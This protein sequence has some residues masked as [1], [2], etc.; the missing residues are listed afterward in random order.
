M[1]ERRLSLCESAILFSA[2]LTPLDYYRAV[3]GGKDG[4]ELLLDSPFTESNLCVAVM[5]K[6]STRFATRAESAP[7]IAAAIHA[8]VNARAGNYFVFCPSFVYMEDLARAYHA[9]YPSVRILLQKRGGSI[10][11]REAFLSQF[12]ETPKGTLVGFCVTGGVFAEGIDL[13]GS[14]LIGAAVVGV[15]IP[16]P[17]PEREAMCAYYQDRYEQGKQFAYFY[18]GMNRVLQAA[19]RVIRTEDDHGTLLLI[20]DRFGDPL[21]R[22]LI[23]RH[24]RHLKLVGD[25]PAAARLF[26]RFWERVDQ[27]NKEK[28]KEKER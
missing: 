22:T 17:S 6:I 14:R 26:S 5:D 3:L 1:I 23:P 18:P 7:A 20:D 28:E 19:G 11:E 27:D 16:Q 12:T 2:T 13:A 21:Y 9:A 10:R 25:P 4:E 15:G 8:M 24:W